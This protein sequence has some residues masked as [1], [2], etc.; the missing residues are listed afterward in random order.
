LLEVCTGYRCK[1]RATAKNGE[2]ER[3]LIGKEKEGTPT[4]IDK[5]RGRGFK[6]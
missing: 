4:S 5:I 6:D 3:V 2:S 1:N